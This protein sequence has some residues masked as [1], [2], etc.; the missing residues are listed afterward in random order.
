MPI[1]CPA[2]GRPNSDRAPQCIYYSESLEELAG[3]EPTMGAA[4]IAP[5]TSRHFI[6][7][8]PQTGDADGRVALFAEVVGMD[9]YDARL[10]LQTERPRLFRRGET[11]LEDEGLSPPLCLAP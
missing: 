6:I 4:A 8:A 2:C 9:P 11:L 5:A 10:A 3:G 1:A 7:L